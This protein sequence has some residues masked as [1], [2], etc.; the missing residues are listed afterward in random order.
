[1]IL[2]S[3]CNI[4]KWTC[5]LVENWIWNFNDGN[6]ASPSRIECFVT[7]CSDDEAVAIAWN[8][9]ELGLWF[10]LRDLKRLI[11]KYYLMTGKC[12]H[13]GNW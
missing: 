12:G 9:K 7:I 5:A 10:W 4:H 13:D 3:L 11:Y 6:W 1:M 8:E 2:L